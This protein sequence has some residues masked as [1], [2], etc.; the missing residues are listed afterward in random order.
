MLRIPTPA[1]E[2]SWSALAGVPEAPRAVAACARAEVAPAGDPPDAAQVVRRR[3]HDVDR[4]GGVI[5]PLDRCLADAHAEPFRRDEQLGVE[6]PRVVLDQREELER[7]LAADG[8]EP[9]LEVAQTATQREPHD[10]AVG[11]RDEL[12]FGTPDH[13]RPSREP[14]ADRQVA[15]A[16]EN[17]PDQGQ[18]GGERGGEVD[19]HVGHHLGPAGRPGGSQR[20]AATLAGE[21]ER[22]DPVE[23]GRQ[24]LRRQGGAVGAA[25]V[26]DGDERAERE[27]VVE[28]AAKCGDVLL[29]DVHLVVDGND[30]LDRD[31]TCV[32][33]DA[34]RAASEYGAAR[35]RASVPRADARARPE[36]QAP[37]D[38]PQGREHAVGHV[39]PL[40][41][42]LPSGYGPPLHRHMGHKDQ[43][44]SLTLDRRGF[45]VLAMA[46]RQRFVG[47]LG[48]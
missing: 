3:R 10:V 20:V 21:D 47:E 9:A 1:K 12:A 40:L 37:S 48:S 7:A 6:E 26:G 19:V 33:R 31:G 32:R 45:R 27:R 14:G 16:R 34:G 44:R 38:S 29:Q 17:G 28:V 13:L 39:R 4:G 24:P 36:P 25:V 43:I 46:E 18:Q 35:R 11:T 42:F 30:D 8:L 2:R 41:R 23:G 15:V 22:L 5:G